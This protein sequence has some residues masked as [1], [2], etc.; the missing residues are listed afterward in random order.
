MSYV[1]HTV[2]T[3][4]L[5]NKSLCHYTLLLQNSFLDFTTP[6]N[7]SHPIL[8]Y[9]NNDLSS[10]S[11]WPLYRIAHKP[12][13]IRTRS[14]FSLGCLEWPSLLSY[15]LSASFGN[16][17]PSDRTNKISSQGAKSPS[18]LSETSRETNTPS[19]GGV[20]AV[21]DRQAREPRKTERK[22]DP[23]LFRC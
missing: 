14:L 9:T 2:Q 12:A 18:F 4:R 15:S 6:A 19:R 8:S 16:I 11:S 7:S 3:L 22:K 13:F 23:C 17:P 20:A 1:I 10:P 5:T 21:E